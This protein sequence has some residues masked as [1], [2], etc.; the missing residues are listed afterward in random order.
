MKT[1]KF[2]DNLSKKVGSSAVDD[3]L[4]KSVY[5]IQYTAMVLS[6]NTQVDM[7]KVNL[8]VIKPW[9]ASRI[10]KILGM[11]DEVVVDYC[12]VQLEK[13]RVRNRK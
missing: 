4:A 3:A 10:E 9:V 11:E 8:D 1:L 5:R 6:P 7:Q 13:S 2:G 12:I